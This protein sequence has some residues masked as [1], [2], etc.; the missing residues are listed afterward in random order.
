MR[1]YWKLIALA[2]FLLLIIIINFSGYFSFI[3]LHL[4]S[5]NYLNIQEFIKSNFYIACLFFI[6]IYILAVLIVM[7]GAWLLTFTGGFFFGWVIGSILTIFGATMG[8]CILFVFSKSIFGKY[9]NRKIKNDKGMFSSFEKNI[10]DNAFNY[11]L[12]MRLMPLFPFVFVNIAP[13][14]L[15]VRLFTYIVTTFL[16]IIPATIIYSLLGSGASDAFMSG[17][18]IHIKNLVSYEII[19]G[20]VGLSILSLIPIYIKYKNNLK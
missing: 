4:I 12:F 3:N 16:G 7:P 19:I 6:F 13:A 9:L 11:L 5:T 8:A 20:L 18:L 1:K 17:N 2:T 14:L 10:R 15:D